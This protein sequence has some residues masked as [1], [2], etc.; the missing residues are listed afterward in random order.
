MRKSINRVVENEFKTRAESSLNFTS[1]F[2]PPSSF[3]LSL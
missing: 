3:S 2:S 1:A